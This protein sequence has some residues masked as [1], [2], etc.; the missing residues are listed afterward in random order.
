MFVELNTLVP[1][2][3]NPIAVGNPNELIELERELGFEF[4]QSI[5]QLSIQYGRGYFESNNVQFRIDNVFHPL[6][7]MKFE[8]EWKLM[9]DCWL[10]TDEARWENRIK[11][12]GCEDCDQLDDAGEPAGHTFYWGTENQPDDW[13]I[14]LMTNEN[15]NRPKNWTWKTFHVNVADFLLAVFKNEIELPGIAKTFGHVSFVPEIAG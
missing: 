14:C 8:F 1:P 3:P 7:K 13:S 5:K 11:F 2:P 4:P 9:N 12:G 6:F 15:P 10:K